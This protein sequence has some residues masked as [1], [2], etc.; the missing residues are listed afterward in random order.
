MQPILRRIF[1][2]FILLLGLVWI[3]F[4]RV[5]PGDDAII[6]L[7]APQVGFNAPDFSLKTMTGETIGISDFS[8]QPVIINFW[9]SWCPP[10]RAE[11]PAFQAV[12]DEYKDRV[13][14]LA[15][16]AS[17]LDT[18]IAAQSLVSQFALTFPILLDSTGSV[19]Q[20]YE[21]TSLPTTFFVGSDGKIF[22][23][24]IGGPLTEAGLR[25]RIDKMFEAIP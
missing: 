15:I 8:G 9:A 10:C 5:K 19:Q 7:S 13:S 1:S 22:Q 4:S 11:M 6:L 3:W 18:L 24:E 25:T 21:I 12:Y 16:N 2:I 17:D 14:I 23:I 20:Q